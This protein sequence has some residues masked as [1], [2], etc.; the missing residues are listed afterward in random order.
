M[1]MKYIKNI[2]LALIAGLVF[3]CSEDLERADYV[4]F[5]SSSVELV[6]PATGTGDAE[7]LVFTTQKSGSDRTFSIVVDPSTTAT[8][9]TYTVPETITIPGNS[10][11]GSFTIQA[12][13]SNIGKKIVL[14]FVPE[15]GSTITGQAMTVNIYEECLQEQV[16]LDI[17]FD[18]YSEEFA[19]QIYD[20]NEDQVAGNEGFGEYPRATF[21]SSQIR[22]RICL[23]AGTYI[24]VA[25]DA[26]G[27][28]LVDSNGEG[29][30]ALRRVSDGAVLASGQGAF[31]NGAEFEFTLPE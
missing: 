8:E 27:D 19:W 24:F 1:R 4:T 21:R 7:L 9:G 3:A 20:E 11:S 23:P 13:A 15:D 16:F 12:N 14:K 6:T 28:G 31:D 25:Y 10:T 26:Y 30:F 2:S 29:F 5:Q 18:T 17:K 22:E